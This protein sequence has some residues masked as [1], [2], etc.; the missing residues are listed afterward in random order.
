[1]AYKLSKKE[2]VTEIV[3]SGKDP[4]YF[5]NNYCRISHPMKGLI[6]FKTYPYQDDLLNDYNDFRFNVILKARQMGVTTIMAAYISWMMMFHRDKN[7]LI[8]ATKFQTAS[9]LVKK[10][11]STDSKPLTKILSVRLFEDSILIS[12]SLPLTICK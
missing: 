1:M 12:S 5:I 9:T 11:I 7:I 3:R 6:Q 2:I 4:S 10:V 8:M